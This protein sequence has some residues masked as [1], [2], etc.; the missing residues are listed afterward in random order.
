[1]TDNLFIKRRSHGLKAGYSAKSYAHDDSAFP[2]SG[3][4]RYAFDGRF[5]GQLFADFVLGLP[6]TFEVQSTRPWASKRV[7]ETGLYL[8]DDWAMTPNLTLN[9]G[10]RFEHETAPIDRNGLYSNAKI[11]FPTGNVVVVVPDEKA[12]SNVSPV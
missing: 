9:L 8:Q 1:L 5:T 11:D 6:G 4:G 3:F 2:G 10:L 7:L 12:L